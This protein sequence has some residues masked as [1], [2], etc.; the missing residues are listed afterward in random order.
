MSAPKTPKVPDAMPTTRQGL[1][2]NIEAAEK[3]AGLNRINQSNPFGSITY[4]E[5]GSQTVSLH[6][7]E[8]KKLDFNRGVQGLI[9]EMLMGGSGGVS[10]LIGGGQTV[11]P[12]AMEA[13]AIQA[14]VAPQGQD[15]SGLAGAMVGRPPGME[16]PAYITPYMRQYDPAM[17]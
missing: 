15:Y 7:E 11:A 14:P 13:P 2:F 1:D 4:G 8:Q 10:D 9:R 17:M 12:P 16:V 3:Q 6:P 5:D